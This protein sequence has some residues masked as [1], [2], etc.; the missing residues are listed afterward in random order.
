MSYGRGADGRVGKAAVDIPRTQ[1]WFLATW[2]VIGAA[3]VLAGAWWLLREPLA[4][5]AAPLALA[6]VIVY[7]LN[8]LV[9]GFARHGVPRI[10]GTLGAY[11][12]FFGA[13]AALVVAV[14]PI[15][16]DQTADFFE[17]L[18]SIVDAIEEWV[19]AQLAALG[20]TTRLALNPETAEA[21]TAIADF[22]DQNRDQLVALLQGATS[23]LARI[24]HGLV[25]LIL[26]PF[27]AFYVLMDLPRLTEG[28]KRLLPPGQRF[29]VVDVLTRI[30]RTVGSYF[31]GQLLVATFVGV[32]TSIGLVIVG[33]PFWALVGGA[34]GAFNLVPLLGPFVGGVVG[35][36]VALTVGEGL[37]QAIAV[38]A[39]MTA[40]Q[41][42]D[43]HV[44]TPNIVSKTVKVHPVTVILGLL[45]AG[46][47]FGVLGMLVAI[48]AIAAAKLVVM[49]VLVTRVPAMSHLAEEGPGLFEEHRR[50]RADTTLT[51][52]ARDLRQSWERRRKG[53]RAAGSESR[54]RRAGAPADGPVPGED[55]ELT[56]TGDDDR[57]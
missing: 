55:R 56:S 30:G 11:L 53:A 4:I 10:L 31:R 12:V 20:V 22:L 7:L 42:V 26:A 23:L 5:V 50:G 27:L 16:V 34:T 15:L 37:G 39:V 48:P 44:I 18:P 57:R 6:G 45:V 47:L 51:G 3:I 40:V 49:Y 24:L 25:A 52:L 29:E 54:R 14:G 36:V 35:V 8:P 28:T 43:N 46:T 9:R 17:E 33:L 21:Q 1:R 19:N 41:Q 2:T 13:A 32:A 38:V